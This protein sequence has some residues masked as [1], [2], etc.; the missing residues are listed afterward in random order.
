[1]KRRI[2][3]HIRQMKNNVHFIDTDFKR[4]DGWSGNWGSTTLCVE[5][6]RKNGQ[7]AVRDSKNPNQPFLRFSNEEWLAFLGGAKSG[8]FDV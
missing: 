5:V 7:V 1:M 2:A 6:A 8:L 4:A 3:R